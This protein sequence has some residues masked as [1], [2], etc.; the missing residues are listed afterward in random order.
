MGQG[1]SHPHLFAWGSFQGDEHQVPL[2]QKGFFRVH[3]SNPHRT[4]NEKSGECR[5]PIRPSGSPCWRTCGLFG[6]FT[7]GDYGPRHNQRLTE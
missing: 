1:C 5:W 3:T 2:S 6:A 7:V 4:F